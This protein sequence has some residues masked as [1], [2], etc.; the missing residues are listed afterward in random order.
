MKTV[1]FLSPILNSWPTSNRPFVH[2]LCARLLAIIALTGLASSALAAGRITTFAGGP[3]KGLGTL[4][5][6]QPYSIAVKGKHVYISDTSNSVIRILDGT[7]QERVVAGNLTFGESGDGGPATKAQLINLGVA[8]DFAGNIYI[9]DPGD[10]LSSAEPIC[11]IRKVTPAGIISTVAGNGTCGYSGDGGPATKAQL[12][13]PKDVT[14]DSI[15]NLYIADAFNHVI[16]KVDTSGIITTLVNL[17][18]E[19][20]PGIPNGVPTQPDGVAVDSAGNLFIA[21]RRPSRVWKFDTSGA[22]TTFAGNGTFGFSGDGGP[23]ASAQLFSPQDIGVDSG[24]NVY[25]ADAGNS[26]IRKVDTSGVITTVAGNG[27]ADYSGDGGPATQAA[28]R[29]ASVGVDSAGNLYIA[30]EGNLRVRKVNPAGIITTV[31]GTGNLRSGPDGGPPATSVEIGLVEGLATAAD[32]S[33]FLTDVSVSTIRKVAPS[34][35]V[36][37]VVGNGTFGFSGDGGPAT[38]AQLGFP[39]GV[40]FNRG[41][42]L[43]IADTENNRVRKVNASGIITT[44]AGNGESGYGGDGGPARSAQLNRPRAVRFDRDGNLYIAD[45]DNSVVRK[46][47]KQGIITTIAGIGRLPANTGDGGPAKK[48]RLN[49]PTAL[50]FDPTG[51][52]YIADQ[53]NNN[54][55]KVD[56]SRTIS[57]IAGTGERGFGGDYGPATQAQLFQPFGLE[58]DSS[59]NLYIADTVNHRIRKVD[60]SGIIR[61]IAGTGANG[62]DGGGFRGDGGPARSARLNLPVGLTL[63]ASGNLYIGDFINSRIRRVHFH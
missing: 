19:R 54:V 10:F 52:L 31:A 62:A 44:V 60:A 47:N 3:G 55:R 5:G 12:N 46:V 63:D 1:Y 51:N 32:G 21:V 45:T 29:P 35:T 17:P 22:L 16:R 14:V 6:Q 39:R 53:A 42:N 15:G 25:I 58:F 8:V 59:G 61:T 13:F 20:I 9:A 41:G 4:F 11:S 48:A 43:Y 36:T 37:T 23:A 56:T 26:R 28:L 34:G 40:A 27:T 30:D 33:V 7:G 18:N 49:S 57:T 24:G 2:R 50:V 38:S